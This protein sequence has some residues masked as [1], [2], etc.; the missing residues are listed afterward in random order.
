MQKQGKEALNNAEAVCPEST[1][2]SAAQRSSRSAPR[3]NPRTPGQLVCES[4][5]ES[6]P[7]RNFIRKAAL[8]AVA[9]GAGASLLGSAVIP[10][11]S[12]RSA[13]NVCGTNV[14]AACCVVV[15]HANTNKGLL[16]DLYPGLRF[17]LCSGEGIASNRSCPTYNR[18][19]LNFYTDFKIRMSITNKGI[20]GIGDCI[21]C[22][23]DALLYVTRCFCSNKNAIEGQAYV[24]GIGVVGRGCT[25]V[26]GYGELG[27]KGCGSIGVAG[28]G[29]IIGVEGTVKCSCPTFVPALF[30]NVKCTVQGYGDTSARVTIANGTLCCPCCHSIKTSWNVAVAG[31]CNSLGI[32]SGAFYLEEIGAGAKM[33]IGPGGNIGIGTATPSA[34]LDVV[35]GPTTVPLVAQGAS[36]QSVN[37]QQWE[38]GSTIKSVVNNCGWLGIGAASAPTTLHVGGSVSAKVAFTGSSNYCM[39]ATDFA[40]FACHP[41]VKVTLP[42]A[43]TAAGRIVFIK[44]TSGGSVTVAPFSGNCIEGST[45]SKTLS[46]PYDSLMLMSNGSKKWVL[47]GNSVGD[48]FTS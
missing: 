20:V 1:V 6:A 23:S 36:N 37:L 24:G 30:A 12:A 17:G 46:K 3:A 33:V 18:Y 2:E 35:S 43:D 39:G 28:V 7:R 22:C 34:L 16:G 4:T 27:V 48:A 5:I 14:I 47:M 13:A 25:G 40:V 26:T 32:G 21:P 8:T 31:V 19:G 45:S 44:N 29:G 15:N 42:A 10:E 38:K 41:S 11:S 9:A